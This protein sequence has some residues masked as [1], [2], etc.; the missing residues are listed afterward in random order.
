MEH[1]V[2]GLLRDKTVLLATHHTHLLKEADLVL[3]I[4]Q[5]GRVSF[6]ERST[7]PFEIESTS[8][9][10]GRY[11]E[12][13]FPSCP[14][15]WIGLTRVDVR[16]ELEGANSHDGVDGHAVGTGGPSASTKDNLVETDGCEDGEEGSVP[17][18][19]ALSTIEGREK[20]AVQASVYWRYLKAIGRFLGPSVLVSIA[21]MQVCIV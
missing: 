19:G 8:A 5:D 17:A 2:R 13:V 21:L 11:H 1:C 16:V 4:E 12:F 20:G 10:S 18:V 3:S 9:L 7:L 14:Y 15:L 6:V